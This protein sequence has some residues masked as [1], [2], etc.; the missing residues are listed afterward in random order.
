MLID[1]G[2][3]LGDAWFA[4]DGRT[5]HA[6]YLRCPDD[7]ARHTRWEIAHATTED[8]VSWELHGTVISPAADEPCLATGSVIR[9]GD[10]WLMAF[11]IGWAEARPGIGLARS[12]DLAAW[13]RTGIGPSIPGDGSIVVDRPWGGR[14]PT[15]WRDP[16]LRH[17]ADGSIEALVC[18]ARTDRPADR[19]GT[20][21]TAR[22]GEDGTW[23]AG[24]ALVV[25]P[26]GRELECP[27][28]VAIHGR[29]FLVASLW[30][31]LFADE[32]RAE[33]ARHLRPGTWALAGDGPDGPFRFADPEPLV[34]AAHPQQPYAGQVVILDDRPHLLGTLW[35]DGEPDALSDPI[36]LTLDGDRLVADR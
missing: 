26:I 32:V 24:A 14:P 31:H 11:T 8:L 25:E 33:H 19:A 27:Q 3:H 30:P 7:V 28:V 10:G 21:A 6:F 4:I 20:V 12:A 2:H 18:A 23:T 13:E 15:H 22:R 17:R 1:P 34:P 16:F 35:R 5:V 36:P 9:D 29:W